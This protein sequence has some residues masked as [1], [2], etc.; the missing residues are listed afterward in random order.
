MTTTKLRTESALKPHVIVLTLKTG[1]THTN[2][3]TLSHMR[4]DYTSP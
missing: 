1:E 4:W 3:Y 2:R